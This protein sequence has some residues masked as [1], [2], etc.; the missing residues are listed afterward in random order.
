[1]AA[2]G[3]SRTQSGR[4][5]ASTSRGTRATAGSGHDGK[6]NGL[7]ELRTTATAAARLPLVAGREAIRTA[8]GLPAYLG[9]GALAV[10][11]VVEWPVA[12][13]AGAGV[14]ALR[15]WGPAKPDDGDE[16]HE[17]HEAKAGGASGASGAAGADGPQPRSKSAARSRAKSGSA[18]K[19][20]SASRANKPAG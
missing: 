3:S 8:H 17:G 16:G 15:R 20:S 12:A 9:V 19:A 4:T 5:A 10:A 18:K 6:A 7:E 11:G 13:A 1:M 14:A 2:T